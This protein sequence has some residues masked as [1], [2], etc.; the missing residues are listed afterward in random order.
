MS[1][2]PVRYV[3]GHSTRGFLVWCEN[4]PRVVNV[5]VEALSTLS[6]ILAVAQAESSLGEGWRAV[7][8]KR[9]RGRVSRSEGVPK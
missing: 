7:Y 5:Y 2:L 1:K 8:V 9:L 6:P 3:G 4:G